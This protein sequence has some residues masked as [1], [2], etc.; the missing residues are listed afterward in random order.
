M[1]S[2]LSP[3]L[4]SS[5]KLLSP[6][7]L[8]RTS[9]TISWPYKRG[10]DFFRYKDLLEPDL[11]KIEGRSRDEESNPKHVAKMRK[12]YLFSRD[13]LARLM[14]VDPADFTD[15]DVDA[16]IRYLFPSDLS[17]QWCRPQL[18]EL[19]AMVEAPEIDKTR[20]EVNSG[21]FTQRA[22]LKDATYLLQRCIFELKNMELDGMD[23]SLTYEEDESTHYELLPLAV[24][25]KDMKVELKPEH[26]AALSYLVKALNMCPGRSRYRD[27]ISHIV[28]NQKV[29]KIKEVKEAGRNL[30]MF[31]AKALVQQYNTTS[32]VTV[33][34][35][36]GDFIV[37]GES[38]LDYFPDL[39]H[40]LHLLAPLRLTQT[41]GYVDISAEISTS[42]FVNEVGTQAG[43]Q[44]N[45]DYEAKQ[46][47]AICT[48]TALG[49][50]LAQYVPDAEPI[51]RQL[52]VVNPTLKPREWKK[53]GKKGP[54]HRYPWRKR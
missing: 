4:L 31:E 17:K 39:A 11:N 19:E 21:Y 32:V 9:V 24:L 6:P 3:L 10:H 8:Y 25:S 13:N 37:N 45:D 12:E 40:R 22:G 47:H 50:A 51:L 15:E 52:M 38:Y 18:K 26:S 34:Y 2:R 46:Q 35:G 23:H 42:G 30:N 33:R 29:Q 36:T 7:L 1:V 54:R 16:S 48:K 28:Q 27:Q 14:G 49:Q 41:L 43:F 44:K 5:T 53:A 20:F